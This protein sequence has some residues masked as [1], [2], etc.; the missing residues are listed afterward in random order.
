MSEFVEYLKE[1]FRE[2]G[3][4][5]AR[6]MFGGHGIFFDGLMIGLVAD[7]CLYLKVDAQSVSKFTERGLSQFQYPKGDKFVGMSYYQVPDEVLEEP[8]EMRQWAQ[9][10]YEAARRSRK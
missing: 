5:N 3:P 1:L 7:D 8:S 2:F 4:V 9:L 10:A 6:R